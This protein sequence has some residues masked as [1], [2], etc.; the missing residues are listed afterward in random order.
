MCRST[1]HLT[2]RTLEAPGERLRHWGLATL[3]LRQVRKGSARIPLRGNAG[4]VSTGKAPRK[5]SWEPDS[6]TKRLSSPS[7]TIGKESKVVGA[8]GTARFSTGKAPGKVSREPDSAVTRFSS[9]PLNTGR[10]RKVVGA[11][12]VRNIADKTLS[13]PLH[14]VNILQ[15]GRQAL[16]EEKRDK[17]VSGRQDKTQDNTSDLASGLLRIKKKG[18]EGRPKK[19]NNKHRFAPSLRAYFKARPE[20][21]VLV[22]GQGK[23]DTYITKHTRNNVDSG[24]W[25]MDDPP[26][27]TNN[28]AYQEVIQ[29]GF[30]ASLRQDGDSQEVGGAAEA[31]SPP[32]SQALAPDPRHSQ[33][34]EE[35]ILAISEDIKKDSMTTGLMLKIMTSSINGASTNFMFK[36]GDPK[37]F[38]K[39]RLKTMRGLA[40][41]WYHIR[42]SAKL[43][44]YNIDAPIWDS[45]GTPECF[46]DVLALPIRQAGLEY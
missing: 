24:E 4:R 7:S 41:S 19:N 27:L 20:D 1:T 2:T 36:F 40:E 28:L 44:Y 33:S 18:S 14:S 17:E 45:P 9:S 29:A 8:R 42:Q 21:V 5:E 38:K 16:G 43:T 32:L 46:R 31:T 30:E 12:G 37:F 23:M 26:P 10:I 3:E 22:Q 25:G 15:A 34:M 6:V 39:I 11:V 35:M 13:S